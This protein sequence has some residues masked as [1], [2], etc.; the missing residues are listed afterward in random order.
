MKIAGRSGTGYLAL[1]TRFLR[2][3]SCL[4]VGLEQFVQAGKGVIGGVVLF[5]L[6]AGVHRL[7]FGVLMIMAVDAEQ[8]PVAAIGRVVVVVVVLVMHCQ[9]AQ[10]F[11]FE[12]PAAMAAHPRK[13]FQGLFTVALRFSDNGLR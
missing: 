5:T 4:I 1:V 8:L 9:L 6:V 11:A 12:I 13:Q 2:R 3:D 10:L 7:M